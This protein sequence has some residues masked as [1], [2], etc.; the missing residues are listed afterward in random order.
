MS[1]P[2]CPQGLRVVL[3]VSFPLSLVGMEAVSDLELGSLNESMEETCPANRLT[4]PV[5]S[6]EEQN[7]LHHLGHLG[8]HF[9]Q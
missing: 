8:I 3:L 6:C 4:C 7:N 2:G 5:L 9:S 1:L